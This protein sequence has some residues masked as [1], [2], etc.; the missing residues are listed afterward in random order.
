MGTISM[1]V[2]TAINSQGRKKSWVA[3]QL[4][5]SRPTLD[6]RL[7]EDD[8]KPEEITILKGIGILI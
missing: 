2:K 6:S 3:N 5:I 8:W 7:V 4:Q 1:S